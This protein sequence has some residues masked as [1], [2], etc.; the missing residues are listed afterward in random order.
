QT[1][2]YRGELTEAGLTLK[3]EYVPLY[4]LTRAQLAAAPFQLTNR[5]S[6]FKSDA[7]VWQALAEDPH[8]VVSPTYTIPGD[9]VT[10]VGPEGPVQFRVAAVVRN[11]GL[12]GMAGSE[13][14]MAAFATLP[15]GTTI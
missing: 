9:T 14:A 13:T 5:E 3:D 15:V 4:S 12:W 1:R 8:L 10:L 2:P 7:E 6:R 11:I